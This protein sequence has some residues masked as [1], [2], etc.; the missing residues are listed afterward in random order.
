MSMILEQMGMIDLVFFKEIAKVYYQILRIF[1][2]TPPI[3]TGA[4]QE[5][6]K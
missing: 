5:T 2:P 1:I 6:Y 4:K 3:Q